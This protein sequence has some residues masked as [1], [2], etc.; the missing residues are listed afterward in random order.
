M[1]NQLYNSGLLA[2]QMRQMK[3]TVPVIAKEAGISTFSVHAAL[4][5]N[6]STLTVLRRLS[7]AL[8]IKWGY[9]TRVDLQ[10]DKQFRRAVIKAER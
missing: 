10:T 8:N 7:D 9:I 6:L 4:G 2:Y 3:K 5:G 1:N